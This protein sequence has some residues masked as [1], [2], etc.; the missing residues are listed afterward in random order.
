[1]IIK[2]LKKAPVILLV[3][4]NFQ[5]AN[6]QIIKPS[7]SI[8]LTN[9][10]YFAENTLG[11][12][13]NNTF[14]KSIVTA[15]TIGLRLEVPK[16]YF[17]LES[18]YYQA[19]VSTVSTLWDKLYGKLYFDA[20]VYGVYKN[21]RLSIFYNHINFRNYI[22]FGLS[23]EMDLAYEHSV[24]CGFSYTKNNYELGL[25]IERVWEIIDYDRFPLSPR[26]EIVTLRLMRNFSLLKN[27][28]E[29][30]KAFAKEVDDFFNL[31]FGL[32]FTGNGLHGRVPSMPL[33]KVAPSLGVEFVYRNFGIY[34]RRS[35]WMNLD[36]F[37]PE[38]GKYTS[39]NNQIGLS[40][41]FQLFGDEQFTL[42]VHHVWNYT[43]GQQYL[44][45]SQGAE[46]SEDLLSY[47]PQNQGLGFL[48]GYE[49]NRNLD[50]LLSS[51]FYYKA[52]PELGTGIN[53]E[54]IRIGL[55]YNL[56]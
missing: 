29:K 45:I 28:E 23:G 15:P 33:L 13:I 25:R 55:M 19:S 3:L 5:K 32:F 50:L 18:N 35:V 17:G 2:T 9:Y 11:S 48:I 44:S 31:Q 43:R 22:D 37:Y 1:M 6:C 27:K 34:L 4:L 53:R 20:G 7:I 30:T 38:A 12:T 40:Y 47:I 16:Y 24:G 14:F 39:I 52:Y 10:S 26:L 21:F 41:D 36:V 49:L 51:D 46:Y 54:S 56:R 42:G 8:G